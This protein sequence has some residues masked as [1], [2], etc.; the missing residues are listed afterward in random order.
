MN[1]LAALAD[2]QCEN[3]AAS[4]QDPISHCSPYPILNTS[5]KVLLTHLQGVTMT[6]HNKII[7]T[8]ARHVCYFL[9]YKTVETTCRFCVMYPCV[10]TDEYDCVLFTV[11][12][13]Y[14]HQR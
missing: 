7:V 1:R 8:H 2:H 12:V 14:L 11:T 6:T 10:S 9:N 3:K 5:I 4:V 13:K